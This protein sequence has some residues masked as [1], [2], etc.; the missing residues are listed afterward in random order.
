MTTPKRRA[1]RHRLLADA[2][3]ALASSLD[4]EKAIREV[5]E[6][7]SQ[8]FADW[9][10]AYL[11]DDKGSARR[12]EVTTSDP[13]KRAIA[14]EFSRLPLEPTQPFLRVA[15]IEGRTFLAQQIDRDEFAAL[16]TT[17]EQAHLIRAV[18]ARSLIVVP[19]AARGHVK[20]ALLFI[21]SRRDGGYVAEDLALAED[22]ARLTVLALDNAALYQTAKEAIRARDEVL[23][24]VAHDLRSPLNGVL[25]SLDLLRDKLFERGAGDLVDAWITSLHSSAHSMERIIR[26]LLE[27]TRLE[28]HQV[29]LHCEP[30]DPLPLVER[31]LVEAAALAPGIEIPRLPLAPL[32]WVSADGDRLVEVLRN[33]IA[34]LVKYRTEESTTVV[35]QAAAEAAGGVDFVR[36]SVTDITT[37]TDADEL[38][39][40]FDRF[41][42]AG[43]VDRRGAALG[44]SIAKLLVEMHGGR[45][46]AASGAGAGTTLAFTIPCLA[47]C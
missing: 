25:L 17:D 46:W 36:F 29:K 12:L 1:E 26:E 8:S 21:S 42:Q 23:N 41:W 37:E 28:N 11:V 40:L 16:A 3:V 20:G 4:F 27:I 18:D 31:A 15:L 39:H 19:L 9:C 10:V 6:L 45:I 47:G 2:A 5:S 35:V 13:G 24:V 44:L 43:H 34:N 33:L 14:G 22:L 32:P 7:A 38:E 30:H